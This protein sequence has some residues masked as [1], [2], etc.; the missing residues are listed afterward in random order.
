MDRPAQCASEEARANKD[1]SKFDQVKTDRDKLFDRVTKIFSE[2]IH[3]IERLAR[4]ASEG[5]IKFLPPCRKP[6]C[7]AHLRR[8]PF[9]QQRSLRQAPPLRPQSARH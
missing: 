8:H 2:L 3:P 1:D 7:S 6:R 4:V 9:A 5:N